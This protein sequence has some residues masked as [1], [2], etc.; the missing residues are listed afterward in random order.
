MW[1]KLLFCLTEMVHNNAGIVCELHNMA[2]T[3]SKV[4]RHF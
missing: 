2:K 1:E 3:F 4:G